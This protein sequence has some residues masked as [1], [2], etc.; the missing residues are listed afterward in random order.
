[1]TDFTRSELETFQSLLATRIRKTE[2]ANERQREMRAPGEW[3]HDL[4]Q[5]RSYQ[6]QVKLLAKVREAL[7]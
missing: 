6:Q 7:S 2:R 1:M 5:D 3:T 4:S